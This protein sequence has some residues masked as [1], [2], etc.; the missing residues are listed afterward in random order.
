M[1]GPAKEANWESYSQPFQLYFE[2]NELAI[3]IQALAILPLDY[4]N[5]LYM[6][7]P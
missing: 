2:Q 3:I 7:C 1:H 4:C 6:G 5:V